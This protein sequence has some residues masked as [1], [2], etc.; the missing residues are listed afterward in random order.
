[1]K[2]IGKIL[3]WIFFG[4]LLIC[5]TLFA[6]MDH[7]VISGTSMEPTLSEKE[8]ALSDKYLF[9]II[10]LNRFDVVIINDT[11]LINNQ[12][13]YLLVKRVIGLPGETISYVDGNLYI[14]DVYV[15]ETFIDQAAKDATTTAYASG[16]VNALT[17]GSVTLGTDE[18]FVMGDNR[19]ESFD[20]RFFTNAIT[21]DMII[22]KGLI[23]YGNYDS[24]TPI[25]SSDGISVECSGYNYSWPEFIGW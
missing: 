10:G 7:V 8:V 1:M 4:I 3:Y 18:Y 5:L 11:E 14:N 24:C 12:E 15:E 17:N 2:K 16:F 21:L 13:D 20:S 19:A 25:A 6:G 23:I 9:K 22:S